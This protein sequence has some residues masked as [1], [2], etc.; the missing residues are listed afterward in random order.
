TWGAT[1]V[2]L[3]TLRELGEATEETQAKKNIAQ[4]I[5]VA[6]EQLGNTTAICRKCYVHPAILEAYLDGSLFTYLRAHPRRIKRGADWEL[7]PDE[8][9]LVDVLHD[10]QERA[11]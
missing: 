7:H 3:H 4:A 2:V 1:A 11:T 5:Q 10:L 6:A 8:A 9:L